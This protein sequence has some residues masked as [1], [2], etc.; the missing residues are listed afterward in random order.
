MKPTV[1]RIVN[2]VVDEQTQVR[3]DGNV[4][5]ILPAVIVAV[6]T[7]TCVNLKVIT[8]GKNDVWVTSVS[9]GVESRNWHWPE[10]R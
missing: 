10:R 7:D 9:Y 2:F 1:G 5:K 8:D 6:W 4:Q 3:I